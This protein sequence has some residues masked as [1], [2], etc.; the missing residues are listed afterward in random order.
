MHEVDGSIGEKDSGQ[1]EEISDETLFNAHSVRD[2]YE[3][4]LPL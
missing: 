4:D 1:F 2:G 3:E